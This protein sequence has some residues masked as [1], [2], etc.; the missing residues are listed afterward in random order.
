M[1]KAR[2]IVSTDNDA[3]VSDAR[4]IAERLSLP[5][6]LTAGDDDLILHLTP[7]RLELVQSGPNAPGPVYVDFVGGAIGHRRRFGGGRGQLVAK[8]VGIKKGF[9]PTVIDATAGL[10]RDAFVLAQLGCQV[11]MLERSA[12]VAALLHDGMQRAEQDVEVVEIIERMTLQVSDA[13]SYLI[14]MEESGRPDVVYLDPMHPERSKA[15]MVK[16]EM[17]LFREL[18]GGDED[19]AKLLQ[20]ALSVAKKRVVV[21]RPRKAEAIAGPEPSLVYEGK[22][23]RFDVY[24]CH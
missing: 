1:A 13:K 12:V 5:F 23:T 18:V 24:L 14:N 4:E 6:G 21:K 7:D 2:V 20:V 22:S 16:K 8:A 3:L 10:G 19:D 15:A 11:L 9:T 17:R